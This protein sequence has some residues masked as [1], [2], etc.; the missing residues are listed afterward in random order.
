[1]EPATKPSI[2]IVD[3][4]SAI[5]ELLKVLLEFEGYQVDAFNSSPA[6]LQAVLSR[7][8]D[9]AVFDLM[10]P[11]ITGL[12]LIRAMRQNALAQH[13]P[14]LL[15]S[16]HY[17]DLRRTSGVLNGKGISYLRKPFHIDELVQAVESLIGSSRGTAVR[18][19]GHRL[20]QGSFVPRTGV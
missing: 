16:A 13:T 15:C 9:A 5:L 6:A 11:E 2:I 18:G 8:Y 14:I 20:D 17:G 19:N 7:P 4:D 1:M 10:M 3:D 12:D